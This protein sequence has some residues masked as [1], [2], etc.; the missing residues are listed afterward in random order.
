MVNSPAASDIAERA[1]PVSR[2]LAVTVAL[3]T[4]APCASRTVPTIVPV[5]LCAS[6]RGAQTGIIAV[7]TTSPKGK[8]MEFRFPIARLRQPGA[9]SESEWTYEANSRTRT[10]HKL[11]P[12]A[13]LQ[14][15]RQSQQ[16][17]AFILHSVQKRDLEAELFHCESKRGFFS[18][19]F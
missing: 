3:G 14:R 19:N 6:A 2:S 8:R 11:V 13:L 7:P 5:T 10:S 4:A 9:C 1:K 15:N 18:F 17:F 12:Q 16:L